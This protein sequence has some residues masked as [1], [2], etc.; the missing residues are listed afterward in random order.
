MLDLRRRQFLTLLGG[1]AAAWPVAARAQQAMMPVIGLL[2][3]GTSEAD[4]FR[5]SAFRQGLS[6]TGY[7]EG[8]NVKLEY[9]WADGQYERLPALAADLVSQ[10]VTVIAATFLPAALAAK[11][12]STTIPIVFATGADPVKLGLVASFN[13]PGGNVTGISVL[14]NVIVEKQFEIL[15]EAVP[16]AGLIG[17]LVNPTNSN[18]AGDA[19]DARAAALALGQR[20]TVVNASTESEIE[21]AFGT[22]VEQQAGALTSC[23]RCISPQPNR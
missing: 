6:E 13:R 18:A 8:R 20:T 11:A 3:G 17:V 12:A 22:L 4:A 5:V 14:F 1:A 7:A 15:W 19:Q 9:R 10:R 21:A 23:G 2:G 16:M